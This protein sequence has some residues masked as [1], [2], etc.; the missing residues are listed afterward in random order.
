MKESKT[1]YAYLIEHMYN[2]TFQK[3]WNLAYDFVHKLPSEL[4]DELHE[5][6]NR[7]VDVLDS[8]PLLQMYIYSFGKMHNA[9]LMHA[10]NHIQ[11]RAIKKDKIEIVDYGCG[12]GLA[13]LC[14]HDFIKEHN[15]L[16]KVTRITLIE[17]SPLALSRAELLCSYFYPEAEIVAVNKRFDDLTSVDIKVS[18]EVLTLHLFS[19]IL[20]VESYNLHHLIQIVSNLPS[21]KNEYVIVSPIQNTLRT[22]R[23]KTFATNIGGFIYYE[24]YL[25]KRQLDEDKDWTCAVLL[26]SSITKQE[27]VEFE[28]DKV[29]EEA[30]SFI[31]KKDIDQKGE[32]SIELI[33]RLQYC[34]E[35]G[36]KRCQNQLGI[37]YKNGVGTEKN[38]RLAFEWFKKA[39]EQDYTSAFGN[40][41][42]LYLKGLGVEIDRQKAVQYF[43]KGSDRKHF[44]CQYKLGICYLK[45]I[46]VVADKNIAFSLFMKSSLQ[47][48]S[49]AM[50]MLYKCYLNA[51]GTEKDENSAIKFLK[52]ASKEKHAKSCYI[53]GN[54]YQMG[55][56]VDK[57]EQKSLKLYI[58][59][60][61]IGYAHAQEKLGDVYRQGLLGSNESPKK[62]FNW[63]LKAAEQGKSSA[64]F[65]VGY[66]FA[67][68]YGVK[69]DMKLAFEWYTKAAEQKSPAALN[70]LAICYEYGRGTEIDLAKAAFY[71]EESAK[72]GNVTAQ[73]NLSNCYEKGTGV[74]S[75]P[76]KVFYWTFEAARNGDIESQG[77]IALYHLK[78]YGTAI[79]I[80][81]ALLWYARYYSKEIRIDNAVEALNFLKKEADEGDSQALYVVGKCLQYGVAT[82]KNIRNAYICF[83]KAAELRHIESLIKT[84]RLSSLYE[85]CSIKERKKTYK[86]AYGVKYSEDK[87]ILIDGGYLEGNEY[88]IARGTRVI[89][90][91]ALYSGDVGKIII[92]SS[93]VVIGNNPF[94]KAGWGR[95]SLKQIEC[96]SDQFVVSD[97]ALYTKDKKKLISYFGKASNVTIPDGVE[98]IGSNAFV[99][100]E[101][102]TEIQFPKTLCSIEKAAFEYCLN[103][104]Q[105]SLPESVKSIGEQ[106]F[107]GCESL[108][109]ILSLGGVEIIS[110]EAFC[111]CNIKKLIL[112]ASLIEID[113]NAFNSNRYLYN[114]TLPEDVRR[115]GNYSFAF[116][117][118][119]HVYLNDKLKEIGDLCFFDCPIESIAIPSSIKSIGK[120][121]FIGAM[122]IECKD[123]CMYASENGL[124]YDKQSGDLISHYGETEVALYPPITHVNSFAFYNSE[125]T[126]I[127]I[128]SNI[129]KVSSW[130]FYNARKLE[131]VIWRK[132]KIAEIPM[133]CFGKCSKISKIDIPSCVETVQ[134]GAFFDCTDLR[135]MKF[136]GLAAKANEKIFRRI[137]R[138][139]GV[140]YSYSFRHEL[141]GSTICENIKRE[142]DPSTFPLIEVIVPKGCLKNYSFSR[143]GIDRQ[144]IV[145]EDEKE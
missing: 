109:D 14:Y 41:G 106:C 8:E 91:N 71:Y 107:Y 13:S 57:N 69:K 127:F 112:P 136:Y 6:L 79:N 33:H 86:D 51:W 52:K 49:P 135:I 132:S 37:W 5:S 115:I 34:A 61:K 124:L 110:K 121:P 25:D 101:D 28:C 128:G 17:P 122:A 92:P 133:G 95:C 67:S 90:D 47:G 139:S 62:S 118:I 89:C 119:K 138:P 53:L 82:E 81:E 120:N 50:F 108:E 42:D 21:E 76:C 68:G 59:S 111:G 3:V 7:G 11:D 36:D 1:T 84:H 64:Q 40:I 58:D 77:K 39:A 75:N 45:G 65:Y 125:V 38:N 46:G 10:F 141:M 140:P 30:C 78:G 70:N 116:C 104:R 85:L 74:K 4:C 131:K 93:I 87:K 94:A 137:V 123:D 80:V 60:A 23:L 24:N 126:D 73:K 113:D 19:N 54:Y 143:Y 35:L 26:C 103:L 72:L 63:Y 31:M 134:E 117:S 145:R 12:Q 130:A 97:F 144:F 9:K 32:D 56:F 66:Y 142:V 100:N 129:V 48:C 27:L 15:P 83:E 29:F 102:L 22:Q 43:K 114:L 44:G 55:K 96:H 105:I 98:I 88:R 18:P 99:E 16:Q 2:P 20:D